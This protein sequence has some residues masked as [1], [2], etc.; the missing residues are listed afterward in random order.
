MLLTAH[1]GDIVELLGQI[2]ELD[3]E[4]SLD[5]EVAL[6]LLH[7]LLCTHSFVFLVNKPVDRQKVKVIFKAP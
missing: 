3:Y 6:L 4:Y 2:F 5:F 1:Q 7:E